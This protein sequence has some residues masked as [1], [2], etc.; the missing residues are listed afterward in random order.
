ME[1]A[2]SS[3]GH[4]IKAELVFTVQ[5]YPISVSFRLSEIDARRLD[6]L[7]NRFGSGFDRVGDS[8]RFRAMLKQIDDKL[9]SP[10]DPEEYSDAYWT[11]KEDSQAEQLRFSQWKKQRAEAR[12]ATAAH[13][14]SAS[15]AQRP[16]TADP[17]DWAD[18]RNWDFG[19]SEKAEAEQ[20]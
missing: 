13:S 6:R 15:K 17:E 1:K 12:K 2:I 10:W 19:E 3:N 18:S 7:L 8:A 14:Q 4:E 16:R 11:D 9:V 5:R 20:E